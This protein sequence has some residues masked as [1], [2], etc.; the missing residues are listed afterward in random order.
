MI[1]A[2]SNTAKHPKTEQRRKGVQRDT[3]GGKII[4]EENAEV[5]SVLLE[6]G[7]KKIKDPSM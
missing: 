5:A 7:K 2:G 1:N 4:R 3:L 6:K